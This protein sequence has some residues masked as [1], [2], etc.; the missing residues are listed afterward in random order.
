MIS[1]MIE[2]YKTKLAERTYHHMGWVVWSAVAAAPSIDHH[3]R[4]DHHAPPTCASVG[5]CAIAC[6]LLRP[7]KAEELA[8]LTRTHAQACCP[9][10]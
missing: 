1:E 4:R 5:C 9:V 3:Q 6:H 8:C 7:C 2:K 10:R